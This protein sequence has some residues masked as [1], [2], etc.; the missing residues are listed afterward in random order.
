VGPDGLAEEVNRVE[1]TYIQP[2]K[3]GRRVSLVVQLITTISPVWFQ[4]LPEPEHHRFPLVVREVRGNGIK[5]SMLELAHEMAGQR[6]VGWLLFS[7]LL[8][9]IGIRTKGVHG[10]ST[11]GW[12]LFVLFFGFP[13]LLTWMAIAPRTYV[14]CMTCGKR[15]PLHLDKCRCCE[16]TIPSGQTLL[17]HNPLEVHQ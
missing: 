1:W 8:L 10:F 14:R 5:N 16:E 4:A 3:H 9:A 15:T 7:V 17:I 13:A 6:M 11:A 2:P 12:A